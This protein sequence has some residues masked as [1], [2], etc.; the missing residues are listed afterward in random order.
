MRLARRSA[1]TGR[2]STSLLPLTITTVPLPES[3]AYGEQIAQHFDAVYDGLPTVPA[4]LALAALAGEGPVLDLGAGTGRVAIPLAERGLAV[5]A[6]EL[7]PAM[8]GVLRSKAGDLRLTVVEGDMSA[9][10]LPQRF[11]LIYCI[12]ST[13]SMLPSAEAQRA[14]LERCAAHLA[15]GGRAVFETFLPDEALLRPGNW[16]RSRLTRPGYSVV[17]AGASDPANQRVSWQRIT[18]RATQLSAAPI[19]SR[20]VWPEELDEMAGAA[21]L[22]LRRRT[23]DWFTRPLTARSSQHVSIY[24]RA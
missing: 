6:L 16:V 11:S 8:I 24:E 18:I 13:L 1:L 20:Y 14:C 3:A 10:S 2:V 7:S 17:D 12:D 5:T 9:F 22:R 15:A 4:V 23:E 19:E 21:G